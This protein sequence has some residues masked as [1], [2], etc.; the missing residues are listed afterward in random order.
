MF[1]VLFFYQA[2]E[3]NTRVKKKYCTVYAANLNLPLQFC[4]LGFKR[5]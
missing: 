2:V 1:F 5:R 4:N 3:I